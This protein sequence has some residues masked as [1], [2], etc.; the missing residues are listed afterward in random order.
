M[1]LLGIVVFLV[2]VTMV[3]TI[4]SFLAAFVLFLI[5]GGSDY[6]NFHGIWIILWIMFFIGLIAVI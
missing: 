6:K 3:L 4:F 2:L 1:I 5:F